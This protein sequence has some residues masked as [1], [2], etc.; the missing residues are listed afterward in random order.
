MK[1]ITAHA[2]V[3]SLLTSLE[4]AGWGD[5]TG[6]EWQGVR[7]T[8]RALAAQL[9]HGSGQGLTTA[10]QVASSAGL[11]QRWTRRCLQFLEDLGVIVWHR[12]GIER[13]R[14]TASFVR[15]VKTRLVDLIHAARPMKDARDAEHRA[16]TL[17]RIRDLRTL[18]VR[19]RRSHH[20]E[21]SASPHT[22]RGGATPS[23]LP[24]TTTTAPDQGDEE[25]RVHVPVVCEHDGDGG[26]LK[27]GQ[28]RCP[29]CRNAAQNAAAAAQS[30]TTPAPKI[31]HRALAAGDYE[32][33]DVS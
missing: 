26:L 30:T 25:M 9:P 22:L 4:R 19:S 33:L 31:D 12:G 14:P 28:P 32:L 13:G 3:P 5:L 15:I 20:A 7:T 8:L 10:Q 27:N 16:A 29:M 6:R 23:P 21:L 2:P 11:S 24:K 18:Y 17:A 1:A